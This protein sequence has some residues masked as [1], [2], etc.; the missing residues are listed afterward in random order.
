MA[1]AAPP[2]PNPDDTLSDVLPVPDGANGL[3]SLGR[4]PL[5]RR[6]LLRL[7]DGVIIAAAFWWAYKL[8]F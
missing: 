5:L 2:E 1:A 8:S 4:H 3:D 7:L 6:W